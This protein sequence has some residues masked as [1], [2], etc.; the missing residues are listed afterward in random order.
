MHS[1][2][3]DF[4][5]LAKERY[6]HLRDC[7]IDTRFIEI[8]RRFN[9]IDGVVSMWSCSGHTPEEIYYEMQKYEGDV[10]QPSFNSK[11]DI[12]FVINA[13]NSTSMIALL[14]EFIDTF[15]IDEFLLFRPSI[16]LIQLLSP[17][18]F[19]SSISKYNAVQFKMNTQLSQGDFG[20][21]DQW[22]KLLEHF[23]V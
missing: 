23:G 3:D 14:S 11:S 12:I 6:T 9:N 15:T 16:N 8:V 4:F 10:V 1:V 17:F 5:Q 2:K 7:D 19:K 22:N 13:Q 20:V 18:T 21:Y